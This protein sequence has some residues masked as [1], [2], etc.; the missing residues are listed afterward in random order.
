M[1]A[2]AAGA[3]APRS[4]WIALAVLTLINLFNYMDR[5]MV[6]AVQEKIK[7]DF[8]L[9]DSQIGWLFPAF[10]I[11][12]TVATPIY[13]AIGDRAKVTRLIAFGVGVWSIA[14]VA[15]GLAMSYE[16]LIASRAV[17]GIGEAAYGTLGPALIA[18]Y[19][20]EAI[21]GR[22]FAIFFAAMPVGA[23]LAFKL[24]GLIAQLYTWH[25]A[26]LLVGPPG[27]ILAILALFLP[28]PSRRDE[29]AAQ[30]FDTYLVLLKNRQLV[31]IILGFI[32]QN[33]AVGG[34][35]NWMA[36]FIHR[37]HKATVKEAGDLLGYITVIAGFSGTLLGGWL[38]DRLLRWRSEA[39][40][41]VSGAATLLAVPFVW[42]A[43]SLPGENYWYALLVAEILI[44]MSTGPINSRIVGVVP[45]MQR[46]A[47]MALATFAIHTFGDG[48][49]AEIIGKVSDRTNLAVAAQL[50]PVAI[51]IGGIIWTYAA[52]RGERGPARGATT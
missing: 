42:L 22:A 16:S 21:R 40:L 2:E 7:A 23:A 51:L 11:V 39:Y 4:A 1:A 14:T 29:R 8:S 9:S 26:F 34:M 12:Y 43:I 17:V 49:A 13:G 18:A 45:P 30:G 24:G 15:S 35:S 41:W 19:F 27:L 33:F 10:L 37:Q 5:F 44:F 6:P 36:S 47:A 3:K 20:P 32:A 46:A 28:E 52:W 31:I 25:T 50:I 48:P 38:G